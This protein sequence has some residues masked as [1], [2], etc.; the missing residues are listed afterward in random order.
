MLPFRTGDIVFDEYFTDRAV[1]V[2][3]IRRAM[4]N[5]ERLLVYGERRQGKS[6]AIRQASL[7]LIES[8][9]VVAWV[10]L[11]T[12]ESVT[13][14]VQRIVA[15]V[16]FSWSLKDRFQLFLAGLGLEPRVVLDA[17]GKPGFGLGIRSRELGSA[18]ERELLGGLL[19]GLDDLA[20]D[21]P[22]PVVVVLDEVQQIES[23]TEGGGG[24]L[25]GVMQE[26]PALAYVL[27]GSVLGLLDRLLSARGP[28]HAI[29]RLDLG[30]IPP[31]ELAPWMEDRMRTHGG[32][33]EPGVGSAII[34]RAGPRTEPIVRLAQRAFLRGGQGAR[35][36]R[37]EVAAAFDDLVADGTVAFETMWASLPTSQ[38]AVLRAVASGVT[39]LHGHEARF[40]Y[41]MPA[42]SSITKAT[43]VLRGDG[44]LSHGDPAHIADPFFGAWILRHAMPD[45]RAH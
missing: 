33:P 41:D 26:T 20:A 36:G 42:S 24:L 39:E 29:E 19:R 43:G 15:G 44:H 9:A 31:T 23:L 10:D 16:P 35:V 38:K 22:S 14:V 17:A 7:P 12:A 13:E 21:H 3:R 28:L 30:P 18:R 5:R 6:S 27:A 11:W 1:E 37:D 34:E 45:G 40:A 4:R 25:R 2:D 32:E 8:G